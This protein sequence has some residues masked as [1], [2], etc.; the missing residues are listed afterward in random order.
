MTEGSS[1]EISGLNAD[2]YKASPGDIALA[3]QCYTTQS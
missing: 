2:G 3:M 1:L